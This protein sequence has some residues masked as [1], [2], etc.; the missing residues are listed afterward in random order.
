MTVDDDFSELLDQ[1]GM[2]QHVLEPTSHD[3]T[4]NRYNVRD[5]I[6][7]S[8]MSALLTRTTMVSSYY[9]SDHLLV[10]GEQSWARTK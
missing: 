5:L 8:D 9:L 1:F 4:H 6:I 10:I 7:K 2:K 3:I